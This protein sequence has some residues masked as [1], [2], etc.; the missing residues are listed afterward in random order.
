MSPFL[1]QLQDPDLKK[2]YREEKKEYYA[3]LLPAICFSILVYM[4]GVSVSYHLFAVGAYHTN[5]AVKV[6][7]IDETVTLEH[8]WMFEIVN[9]SFL[10]LFLLILLFH[11]CLPFLHALVCPL[12]NFFLFY[13]ISFVEYD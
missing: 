7:S 1:L 4:A 13:Q 11:T 2:L 8:P 6:P 12:L 3:K 10:G 5:I 9:F